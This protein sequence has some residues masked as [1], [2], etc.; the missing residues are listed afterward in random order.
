MNE[1]PSSAPFW[2]IP[3]PQ[4]DPPGNFNDKDVQ[5]TAR[6][7]L[8]RRSV[9]AFRNLDD[10]A[11]FYQPSKALIV[12]I[13]SALHTGVP[14]LLTGEPGTGKTQVASFIAW[15]FDIP[16]CKF[17]VKSTSQAQDLL[18]EFDAVGYLRWANTG[19]A[20]DID[21]DPTPDASTPIRERFLR[22][23]A[24]WQAYD[25]ASDCVVLIDEI[26]KAPRDFPN[27]LLHEFDQHRFEHPFKRNT[28]IERQNPD[29][30]P[31]L[32]ITS[33]DERRLP[34]AF[35]RRCLFHRIDLDPD[36]VA[37]AVA[38][39]SGSANNP[40]PNLDDERLAIAQQRF[41]ELRERQRKLDKPPSTAEL[42]TWLSVLSAREV[43]ADT[44]RHAPLD[45]LPGIGLLIKNQDD[46]DN[47]AS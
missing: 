19:E 13:N 20:P 2:L 22:R 35:L 4:K 29:R 17:L 31:I 15:F 24:L 41:W 23:G 8:H 14:L 5:V 47:L 38:S 46:F 43:D 27:D 16:L 30:P 37:A 1:S 3:E 11:K 25:S 12:A 32:I 21:D 10:S 18:F 34:D 44:L 28:F 40:F 9:P 36:L 39:L 33:N 42:L 45:D 6:E 7:W 26:D